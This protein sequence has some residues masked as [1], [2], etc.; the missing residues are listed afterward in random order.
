MLYTERTKRSAAFVNPDGTVDKLK[1]IPFMT[2]MYNEAWIQ[3][4][5]AEYPYLL[6]A[7]EIGPEFS[8]LV[9]IGQ[10]VNVGS[11]DSLGFIDNLYVAPSGKIC[12]VETKLFRNQ[13]SR[14]TVIAQAIDYAKELQKWDA[15]R[16]DAVASAYSYKK[17]GMASRMI[18][19][20]AAHGLLTYS[21]EGRFTDAINHCLKSA[22]FLVMIV[23][24]GIRSN[25]EQLADFI[26]NNISMSFRLAL[27][28]L[29]LYPSNDGIIVIP[30]LITKTTV[31]E[32]NVYN[33][34]P[35][36]PVSIFSASPRLP[37]PSRKD[38]IKAFSENGGYDP[39]QVT[40]F[41]ADLDAIDGISVKMSPVELAFRFTVENSKSYALLVMSIQNDH[42]DIYSMPWWVKDFLSKHG[43]FP[44][45]ADDFYT[46]YERYVDLSRCKLP[47]YDHTGSYFARVPDVL[48]HSEEFISA[49]EQFII[50]ISEE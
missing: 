49:I 17:T 15:E 11:N 45:E 50:S 28:E 33:Q 3:N 12:I 7:D 21:D 48:E 38:F 42:A 35:K 14:R 44:M 32:R 29:E 13:E 23:G 16:L 2:D 19:M 1:R 22:S 9:C 4:L 43:H 24:D 41:V 34:S 5:I 20:M 36:G 18:D 25:V 39:D 47:P 27:V 40:E 46:F 37:I 8:P 31:F 10:E 26:S 6:P 30:N